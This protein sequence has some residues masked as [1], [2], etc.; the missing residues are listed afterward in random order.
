[1]FRTVTALLGATVLLAGLAGCAVSTAETVTVSEST[2]LV[3]V[4]TPAEYAEG[5]LDGA[6]L[7]DLNSGEFEAAL[8]Q[9]DPDA[10]YFVYCRT[11]NRSAQ[12]IAMM[13]DAGFT[14]VVNLGSLEQAAD[15][16]QVLVVR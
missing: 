15:A 2:I 12:A 4:R 6:R 5:H 9:L 1:M 8:P 11:G 16:T 13:E 14:N 3:D 7:L 10:E